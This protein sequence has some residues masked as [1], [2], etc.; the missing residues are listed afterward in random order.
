MAMTKYLTFFT[1]IAKSVLQFV[2]SV[3]IIEI[4]NHLRG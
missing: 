1:K 3:D 4:I 2:D